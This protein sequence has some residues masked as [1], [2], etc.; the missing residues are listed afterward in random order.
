MK[1]N[2]IFVVDIDGLRELQAEKPVWFIVR[3]LIQNALDEKISSVSVNMSYSRGRANIVVED[4]S[5]DGFQDLSDA[6]TLFKTTSKRGNVHKRGRFNLGEKQVLCMAESAVIVSTKG[7]ISFDL[8]RGVRSHGRRKREIGSEVS[9]LVKMTRESYDSCCHYLRR[10]LVPKG[11]KF[12]ASVDGVSIEYHYKKPHASFSAL[13]PTVALSGGV[14]RKTHKVTDVDVHKSEGASYIYE[15]GIPITEIDCEYSCDIGMRVPLSIDRDTV[16]P[17]YLKLVYGELLNV[18]I[19]E[20]TPESASAVWVREGFCTERS[21]KDVCDHVLD[22]RYGNKRCIANPFDKRSMDEAISNNYNVVYSSEMNK[23]EWGK[24]RSGGLMSSSSAIFKTNICSGEVVTPSPEMVITGNFCKRI[25]HEMLDVRCSVIFYSSPD[26][27]SKADYCSS[28][29]V[30]RFNVAHFSDK[31]WV[32]KNGVVSCSMLNLIIHE[33]GHTAGWH[34]ET[35][36]HECL[37][38]L[39]SMLA[40]KALSDPSWFK[41]S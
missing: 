11:L 26:S 9:V 18:V 14:M 37:T 40:Y 19:D 38:K 36:Y 21:E 13:L 28:S 3:E 29:H 10:I 4:D 30:L 17:K 34:Y 33:L 15:M 24:V 1:N 41:L 7:C 12:L 23:E 25:A 5:P 22:T 6:Y 16:D 39:G 35:S 31:E 27:S 2:N 8:I 32:L 20:I